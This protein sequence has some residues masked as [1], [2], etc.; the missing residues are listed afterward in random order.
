MLRL[1]LSNSDQVSGVAGVGGVAALNMPGLS[2]PVYLTRSAPFKVYSHQLI[3]Y[4]VISTKITSSSSVLS[5]I[6]EAGGEATLPAAITLSEFKAWIA[7]VEDKKFQRRNR[8]FSFLCTVV[9]VIPVQ[10][11]RHHDVWHH[12]DIM[13]YC[14]GRSVCCWP[15]DRG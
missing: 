6:A 13:D 3:F 4:D 10:T 7:A 15:W 12:G 5:T 14:S 1:C 2:G 9:K 11:V 8:P